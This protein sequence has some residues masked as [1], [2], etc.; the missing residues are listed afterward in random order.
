MLVLL[1]ASP[2]SKQKTPGLNPP[3]F[4]IVT[5]LMTT[6]TIEIIWFYYKNGIFVLLL[7]CF[8]F[9]QFEV[10]D[11]LQLVFLK[12]TNKLLLVGKIMWANYQGWE[13]WKTYPNSRCIEFIDNHSI[14]RHLNVNVWN[15][16]G[17]KWLC[18]CLR[19]SCMGE[20]EDRFLNRKTFHFTHQSLNIHSEN[21]RTIFTS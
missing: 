9:M 3:D 20:C 21:H 16:E 10:M 8:V 15:F 6:W 14:L 18:E 17:K 7:F 4:I 1:T 5:E 19:K 13:L 2:A 11:T 12:I